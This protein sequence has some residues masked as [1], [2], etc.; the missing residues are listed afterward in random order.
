MIPIPA[1][2]ALKGM[3]MGGL[4]LR[5][6]F[7]SPVNRGDQKWEIPICAEDHQRILWGAGVGRDVG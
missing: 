5:H 1:P 4:L 7:R 3:G 6:A 2:Y